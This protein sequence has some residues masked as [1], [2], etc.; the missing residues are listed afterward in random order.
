MTSS[1]RDSDEVI[2]I[3]TLLRDF[4]PEYHHAKFGGDLTTNKEEREEDTMCPALCS[5]KIA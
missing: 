4:V 5:I 2:K 1:T 3:L